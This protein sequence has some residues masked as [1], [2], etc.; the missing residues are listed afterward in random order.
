MVVLYDDIFK[1]SAWE[2]VTT[3]TEGREEVK[4]LSQISANFS[5]EL[6]VKSEGSPECQTIETHNVQAV[7]ATHSQRRWHFLKK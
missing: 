2:L 7:G 5:V 3:R 6:C 4:M 1:N